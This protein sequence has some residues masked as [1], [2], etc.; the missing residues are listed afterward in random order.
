MEYDELQRIY[1]RK[2]FYWGTE[3]NGFA[4]KTVEHAPDSGRLVDIGTGEG[5][6]AV[7]FAEQGFDVLA[8]DIAPNGLAK[9]RRLAA[10]R[11]VEIETERAD[12][13]DF[14]LDGTV[15]VVYSIGTIQYL[16]PENRREWFARSKDRTHPGGL[17]AMFA[18]VDH[19]E[20]PT[21]PDWGENEY[22]YEQGELAGY[23]DDW[24]LLADSAIV[25]DDDSGGEPHQHAAETAIYRKP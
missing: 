19:P 23:Y 13:N 25:F 15:D 9:A 17:H 7:Y 24:E 18:F 16:R 5:R 10:D 4:R 1:G 11:G 2:E 3:E 12:V 14:E 20:I 21:A 22:V 6:D 8:V